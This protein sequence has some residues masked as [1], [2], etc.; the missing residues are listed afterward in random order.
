MKKSIL[1]FRETFIFLPLIYIGFSF[2]GEGNSSLPLELL[3]G[4]PFI[5]AG[6]YFIKQKNVSLLLIA[7]FYFLHIIYDLY[8]EELT[9]NIGVIY[10]YREFCIVYDFL[11][12]A[13]LT[14]CYFK[15]KKSH[16]FF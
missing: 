3:Y 6:L 2:L 13:F 1:F 4:T 7:V 9:N 12:G 8:N 5:V 14:Y 16:N 15:F 10:L 11:V